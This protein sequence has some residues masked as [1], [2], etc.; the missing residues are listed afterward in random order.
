MPDGGAELEELDEL[1]ELEEFIELEELDELAELDEL[2]EL[3]ELEMPE[4][5]D[6]PE[7]AGS[8]P[9]P[10]AAISTALAASS[11]AKA[12][13]LSMDRTPLRN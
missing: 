10:H 1:E 9:F 2:V 12:T 7:L 6:D 11:A 13:R 4:G 3:D 5:M 8:T